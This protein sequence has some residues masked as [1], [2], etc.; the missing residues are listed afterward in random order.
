[1]LSKYQVLLPL[2]ATLLA[3]ASSTFVVQCT[4]RLFDERAD[5]IVNPGSAAPHVHVIVG[6]DG[7]GLDM[8]YDDALASKCSTC[9]VKEDL[10]NYWTPKMYFH[11]KNGSFI[12]VPIDGDN[13]YGARGG[14]AIYYK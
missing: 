5:P 10:S 2:L 1:M 14:M 11:A 9:H 8:T 13:Q 3:P 7:F 6:G 12:P 4:S